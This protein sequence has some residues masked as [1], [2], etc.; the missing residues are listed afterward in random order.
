MKV[1]FDFVIRWDSERQ[2]HDLPS[3]GLCKHSALEDFQAGQAE[4]G[5]AVRELAQPV[6]SDSVQTRVVTEVLI[7]LFD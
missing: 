2:H 7:R 6:N 3:V 5:R 4:N 1:V